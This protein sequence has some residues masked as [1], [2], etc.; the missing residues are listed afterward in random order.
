VNVAARLEGLAEPGGICVSSMVHDQV[1]DKVAFAFEDLGEQKVKNIA[2]PVRVYALRPEAVGDARASTAPL[3][4]PV[5]Q[6]VMPTPSA[7][8]RHYEMD[9]RRRLSVVFYNLYTLINEN[10]SPLQVEVHESLRVLPHRLRSGR[11]EPIKRRLSELREAF[12]AV[13]SEL[14][15]RFMSGSHYY[16]D[17]IEDITSNRDHLNAEIVA[18]DNYI[19]FIDLIPEKAPEKLI[20]LIEPYQA[21][22]RDAN[23]DLGSWVGQCNE[24]I[25]SK[26]NALGWE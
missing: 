13:R 23:F 19:S 16:Y 25:K 4:T 15:E 2:R 3:A 7:L 22:L 6:A 21:T 26:R 12:S 9:D 11:S 1:R 10:V 24:R 17:E 8:R 18:L 20:N 5:P 14:I